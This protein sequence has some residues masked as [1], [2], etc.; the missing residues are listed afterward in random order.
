MAKN[1]YQT[2]KAGFI[3]ATTKPKDEPKVVKTEGKDLRTGK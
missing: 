3:P 2:N 1:Q